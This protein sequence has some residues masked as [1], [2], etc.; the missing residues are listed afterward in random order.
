MHS[1]AFVGGQ[2]W[3]L[4]EEM[5]WCQ[6]IC[7]NRLAA[8]HLYGPVVTLPHPSPTKALLLSQC[9]SK[10]MSCPLQMLRAANA[11]REDLVVGDEVQIMPC[12]DGHVFH[13]PCLKPWL[14]EHNSCPVCRH[15]LPTD[16]DKYERRKERER[17]DAEGARGSANALQQND[18]IFV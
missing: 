3:M 12:N 16:D 5:C 7:A 6:S 14:V 9:H 18:F 8:L 17:E 4:H 10:V 1:A 11:C 2:A 13:P 15:E